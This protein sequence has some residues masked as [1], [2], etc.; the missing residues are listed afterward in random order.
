LAG[1]SL[2]PIELEGVAGSI[3][4]GS[5]DGVS[6]YLVDE[7]SRPGG[8]GGW[9]IAADG[10]ARVDWLLETPREPAE[11]SAIDPL[12]YAKVASLGPLAARE[13]LAHVEDPPIRAWLDGRSLELRGRFVD[14]APMLQF[15][16]GPARV[17]QEK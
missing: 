2:R 13:Q 11:P 5:Y 17:E 3:E 7:A 1:L 4:R 14:G 9:M 6:V 10:D 12:W 16:L 15:E 8:F